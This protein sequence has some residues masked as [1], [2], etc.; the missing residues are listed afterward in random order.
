[1]ERPTLAL[2]ALMRECSVADTARSERSFAR[3]EKAI[4][5]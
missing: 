5:S 3:T 4:R 1:M 2:A